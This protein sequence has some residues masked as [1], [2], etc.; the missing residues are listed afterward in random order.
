MSTTFNNVLRSEN[1]YTSGNEG[2]GFNGGVVAIVFSQDNLVTGLAAK[3][4]SA[5]DAV[6]TSDAKIAGYQLIDEDTGLIWT[7]TGNTATSVWRSSNSTSVTP[8]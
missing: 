8:A 5:T 6:N 1:G 3:L 4:A 7:A 2:A